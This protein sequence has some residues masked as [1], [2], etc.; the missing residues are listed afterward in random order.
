MLNYRHS[1]G[2]LRHMYVQ[3]AWVF[4]KPSVS[5]VMV[6]LRFVCFLFLFFVLPHLFLTL[7]F[8]LVSFLTVFWHSVFPHQRALVFFFKLTEADLVTG[9]AGY[10][11]KS[12]FPQQ[13]CYKSIPVSGD[14][15][16]LALTLMRRG[17]STDVFAKKQK[18]FHFRCLDSI[19]YSLIAH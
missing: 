7:P 11:L 19:N 17:W 8:L 9:R 2:S 3:K 13:N 12:V 5:D 14:W 4:Q 10:H 16:V 15:F 18:M 6:S 1:E